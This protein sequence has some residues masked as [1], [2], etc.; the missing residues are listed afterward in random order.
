MTIAFDPRLDNVNPSFNPYSINATEFNVC[1]AFQNETVTVPENPAPDPPADPPDNSSADQS[2]ILTCATTGD[3]VA[4]SVEYNVSDSGGS[5]LNY[6]ELGVTNN[7]SGVIVNK[8]HKLS[9]N[10]AEG[11]FFTPQIIYDQ[12]GEPENVSIRVYDRNGQDESENATLFN[13]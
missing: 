10:D 3:A 12:R 9:G 1:T 2:T 7:S 4:I 6:I 13:P 8:T 11:T 5:G